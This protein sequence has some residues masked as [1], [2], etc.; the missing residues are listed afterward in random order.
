MTYTELVA[1]VQAYTENTFP[2]A[3]MNTMIRQ[4]EQTIYNTVQIANLRQNVTGSLAI[5]SPYLASPDDLLS[6]YS[7]AVIDPDTNEYHYLI[8][9]DV[10]FMREAYPNPSTSVTTY[11]GIPKYYGIFGPQYT[12]TNELSLI[13]GPTPDKAY[14]AELHYYYYPPSIVPN[15]GVVTT[16]S[17]TAG[18]GY[19]NGTY[20]NLP[21][22][23]GTG[24][25]V[26]VTITVGGNAITSASVTNGGKNY[27]VGDTLALNTAYINGT[28]ATGTTSLTVTS[29]TTANPAGYTW[30]GDNFDSA[31]FNGTM[32]EAIRYMKGEPDLVALY[33]EQFLQS[34]TLLKNLGD[35]KQRMDAYRDGQVRN[36]VS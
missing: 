4:A 34:L 32:M 11:R 8:N 21:L 13:V 26:T 19:A 5:G 10:N 16:V 36:P 3:D 23:G 22:T 24:T 12:N 31:L 17:F 25:G 18:S 29:V 7:L 14:S 28:G 9:K 35:G 20:S 6:I 1:A 27:A 33:K 15:P 2:T 30:L